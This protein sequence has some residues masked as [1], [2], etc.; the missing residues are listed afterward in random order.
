LLLASDKMLARKF[1]IQI[2]SAIFD[3]LDKGVD[4]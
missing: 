2:D 1:D 4:G 3:L